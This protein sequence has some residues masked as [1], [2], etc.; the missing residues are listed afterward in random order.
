MCVY[1]AYNDNK[2]AFLWFI[3][4]LTQIES[5]IN[6]SWHFYSVFESIQYP[7][8]IYDMSIFIF[9][10][11]SLKSKVQ[12]CFIF[13]FKSKSSLS[14]SG[15]PQV[16]QKVRPHDGFLVDFIKFINFHLVAQASAL[17][18]FWSFALIFIYNFPLLFIFT[19]MDTWDMKIDIE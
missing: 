15:N 1:S 10:P 16:T 19:E 13:D 18:N 2:H 17:G 8:V 7:K 11:S 4:V 6:S 3:W 9:I 12:E 5:D 14:H